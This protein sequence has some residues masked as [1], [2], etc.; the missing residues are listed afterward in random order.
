MTAPLPLSGVVITRNEADRIGRCLASLA[1]VCAELLVVD[2]GSTDATVDIAR[3]A[4][5]RVVHQDWLGFAAQKTLATSLARQPWVL[6][7]DADEWLDDGA[8]PAL[9]A[10]FASDRLESC[11]VWCLRRRTRFLGHPL[12]FGGWSR[13]WVHRLSR[14]D[15]RYLPVLV[16]EGPD[17]AGLRVGH[18]D[19]RIE[20]ET[21]RSR[22]EYRAKLSGYA[23]LWASQRHQA[24]RRAGPLAAPVHALAYWLKHYVLQGGFLDGATGWRF[25]ACHTRYVYEK[26]AR[27]RRMQGNAAADPRA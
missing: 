8:G 19:A 9:R 22:A 4:G 5:A 7:L 13:E 3:A 16:H 18:C 26:Y 23:Q 11:D 14:P 27:L 24:G 12:R 17:L 15:M 2:S 20:H 6:L 25:H 1:P 10:L 21:A